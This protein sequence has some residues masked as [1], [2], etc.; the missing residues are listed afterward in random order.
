MKKVIYTASIFVTVFILSF[1]IHAVSPPS[2]KHEFKS[3]E[4]E[5]N[6]DIERRQGE[7]VLHF[8][9]TVFSSYDEIVVERSGSDNGGF[10][11]CKTIGIAE[12]KITGDYYRTSDKFPTT[13]QKDSYYRIK[14]V[15]KDGTVKMFPPILLPALH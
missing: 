11:V 10:S 4:R 1:Q 9:S 6:F 3:T 13:A 5:I 15:S 7:V 2:D 12:T 14:T 8:Q